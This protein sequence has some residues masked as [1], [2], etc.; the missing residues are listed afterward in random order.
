VAGDPV[1]RTARRLAL[2]VAIAL[3]AQTL[4]AVACTLAAGWSFDEALDGFVVSNSVIGLS[5]GLCGAVIAWHRPRHPVGWLYAAG[6][7]C[8]LASAVTAPLAQVLAGAGAPSWLVRLDLTVFAWSWPW[9]IGLVLPLSLLLLPD[10]RLPSPRWRPIAWAVVLTAPLF[11]LEIGLSPETVD[12]LPAGYLTLPSYDAFSRLWTASELRWVA[13][14]LVGVGALAVRY[15]RGDERLR[16]QLLWPGTAAL[17]VLVAVLPWALVAGTP[18]VVLFTIPLLPVALTVG[19]LRHQLLDIRLVVARGVAYA[20]LSAVVLA[21]YAL[22]V[23]VLSGVTSALL[24]ALAALPLRARLQRAVDRLFYGERRDPW[25]IASRIGGGLA[26]SLEEIRAGLRLPF[27]AVSVDG[28]PVAESGSPPD[29]TATVD[30]A[31][32]GQL[33]VGLRPGERRLAPAD[34]R[35]LRLLAAPLAAALRATRLSDELQAS[36]ERLVAAREEER[37]RLRRDLH[38]GLGPLLTG[39][40]MSA[41]AAANLAE[42]SPGSAAELLA[43]VRTDSRTAITEI[44]RIIDD[45]R[46]PAL[47]EL[48]LV[49]ALEARA[50]RTRTRADGAPIRAVV[51]APRDLPQLPAAIEVAAYRIATEAMTNAVRHSDADR[52]VVRVGCDDALTVEVDDD[53]S[54]S[55]PWTAGVGIAGMRERAAELGGRCSAGPAPRGGSVRVRLPRGQP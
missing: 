39:V 3:V 9:H 20:L 52:V 19:I 25:R 2:A 34:E 45:L 47:D 35:V 4:A 18:I 30:L 6:G 54:A 33:T 41:D 44:R 24:V 51:E 14:M 12:G 23:V 22:L 55:A 29:V 31:A 46:P 28:V 26:D 49:G 7:V 38:D 21:G 17:V 36:R 13:A 27:V 1:T 15:R 10:G 37:R 32:E 42:R 48:G 5:F 53:G 8:M 43:S 40:A 16:R 50:A 11:V